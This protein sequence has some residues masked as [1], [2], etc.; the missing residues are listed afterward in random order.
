MRSSTCRSSA[1]PRP[2][3]LAA[4]RPL[5]DPL[6][7]SNTTVHDAPEIFPFP[8]LPDEAVIALNHFLEELYTSFQNHYF[9]QMPRRSDTDHRPPTPAPSPQSL[10][11]SVHHQS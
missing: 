3:P 1:D 11:P 9:A 8:D 4:P 7:R 5:A 2:I 6:P 10:V